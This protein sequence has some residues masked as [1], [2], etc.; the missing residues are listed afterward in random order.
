[1]SRVP[2]TRVKTTS[3][4]DSQKQ[5][6]SSKIC[7]M[8]I[9]N[10]FLIGKL[11]SL[12]ILC[13]KRKKIKRKTHNQARTKYEAMIMMMQA[14]SH[15]MTNCHPG[16]HSQVQFGTQRKV[17][18]TIGKYHPVRLGA[19]RPGRALLASTPPFFRLQQQPAREKGVME[20]LCV[21]VLKEIRNKEPL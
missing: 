18:Q 16:S 10:R 21:G 4:L 9:E 13:H 14:I 1:M 11:T 12:L 6:A 3:S 5:I 8:P 2:L 7:F 20:A 15:V 17:V 19:H